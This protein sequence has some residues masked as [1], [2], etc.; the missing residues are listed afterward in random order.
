MKKDKKMFIL[1]EA[2]LGSLVLVLAFVMLQEKN[3]KEKQKIAVIIE[4]SDDNQWAGLKYGLKKAAEDRDVE[5]SV[6]STGPT[7]TAKEQEKLIRQEV[8]GGADAVILQPVVDRD[9]EKTLQEAEREL[10]VMLIGE[11]PVKRKESTEIPVVRPDN[12]AMGRKLAEELLK[13]YNGHLKGKSLGILNREKESED[14]K[15]RKKGFEEGIKGKGAEFVWSYFIAADHEAAEDLEKQ[16]E[17][18][19]VIAFDD[20]SLTAAGN[21]AVSNNLHGALVYGIGHST[22]A[23]YYL[24]TGA[25]ECLAVPDEFQIGYQSLITLLEQMEQ[26]FKERNSH[27]ISYAVIRRENLFSRE[28]QEILYT[29]SQ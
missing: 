2:V 26:P 12:Y 9:T 8:E 7:L 28:N 24:D 19:F 17:V 3:E 29:M 14:I 15:Q 27:E 13:D 5:L 25:A 11:N 18:D 1:I 22:E 16:P 6:A 4:N 10:P 23:V 21:C 20:D